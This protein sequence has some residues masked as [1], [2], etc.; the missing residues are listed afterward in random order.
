MITGAPKRL[1]RTFIACL[2]VLLCSTCMCGCD[3]FKTT[4]DKPTAQTEQVEKK[5]GESATESEGGKAASD[6]A[7]KPS[8]GESSSSSASSPS[9]E[10]SSEPEPVPEPEPEPE[11]ATISIYIYVDATNA[12]RG[13]FADMTVELDEGATVFDALVA[14]GLP[15]GGSSEYVRSINGLSE[16]DYGK[17][18]GWMYSVNDYTPMMSCGSYVLSDG[19]RVRWYYVTKYDDM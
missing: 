11:A 16:Y 2:L 19:D 17:T 18:S 15:F 13:Y 9:G 8:S 6:E 1:T 5:S 7:A 14:T 4:K 10:S 3:L 12:D